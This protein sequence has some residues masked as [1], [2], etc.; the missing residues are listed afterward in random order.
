[1]KRIQETEI[2]ISYYYSLK[3]NLVFK[4]RCDDHGKVEMCK[5]RLVIRRGVIKQRLIL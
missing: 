3:L 4:I 2:L 1:M 5:P